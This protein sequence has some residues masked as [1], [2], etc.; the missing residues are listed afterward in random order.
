MN[1][2]GSTGSVDINLVTVND[3]HGRIEQSG[4]VRW[5]RRPRRPRSTQI[6]AEN[7]NTVFAPAGDMIG[8]ST[9]TS[10]IQQDV[11]T[12][13]ALNAAGPTSARSAT[14]SSTRA[15]PTSPTG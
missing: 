15:S 9:F 2:R 12:I 3:F 10:F 1:T 5:H 14:T 11:P 8:A 13:E 6:R 7:P 4:A